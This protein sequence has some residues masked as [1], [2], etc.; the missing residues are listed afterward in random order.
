M[1]ISEGILSP[2]VLVAGAALSLAGL[3]IGIKS[4][5]EEDVPKAA[6]LSAVFFTASLIHVN[7]GPSSAHLI[8]SGL[9]GLIARWAAFPIVFFGLLLQGVLFGFGGLSTLGVNTFTMAAPAALF[10]FLARRAVNSPNMA[11][12]SAAGLFCGAV[13]VL[14]SGIL[15]AFSLYLS[16][17]AFATVGYVIVAA[18]LPVVV[19]EGLVAMFLV[20]FLRK[21]RPDLLRPTLLVAREA[22]LA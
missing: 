16:G 20:Q 17:D 7:I 1:H 2:P 14:V 5:K 4:I 13:P 12:A 21:V 11:L 15:V 18:N 10:G 8:L 22:P 9:I 6:I 3:A 19:I